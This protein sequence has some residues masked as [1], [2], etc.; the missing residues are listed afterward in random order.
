MLLYG[1]SG[2]IPAITNMENSYNTRRLYNSQ[3]DW[4][5]I[6]FSFHPMCHTQIRVIDGRFVKNLFY[7]FIFLV[8]KKPSGGIRIER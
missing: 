2:N 5:I 3:D 8:I 4:Y 1:R 6:I 7:Y